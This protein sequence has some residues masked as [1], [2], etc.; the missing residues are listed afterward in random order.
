MR[1]KEGDNGY[2]RPVEGLIVTVDLDTM[3][4]LEVEDHG[5]VPL[6]PQA[7][8]YHLELMTEPGNVPGVHRAARAA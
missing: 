1:A 8:N 4:V 3:A 5:V 2:A 7:G 6:P